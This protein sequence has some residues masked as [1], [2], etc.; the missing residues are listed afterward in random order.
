MAA[1]ASI[2]TF[3][4]EMSP[5]RNSNPCRPD[6]VVNHEVLAVETVLDVGVLTLDVAEQVP[7]AVAHRGWPVQ[8]ARRVTDD[9]VD[10]IVGA[11][12]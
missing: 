12:C 11:R 9:V 1:P 4:R 3:S 5:S 2:Q 8:L 7:V 6:H 10:N